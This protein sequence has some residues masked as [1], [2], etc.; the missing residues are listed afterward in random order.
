MIEERKEG[1]QKADH[2]QDKTTRN[3]TKERA[4]C[5]AGATREE[6]RERESEP[7]Q[8]SEPIKKGT[9]PP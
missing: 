8:S 7:E 9:P 2:Q 3:T 1:R 6:E 5:I 4:A